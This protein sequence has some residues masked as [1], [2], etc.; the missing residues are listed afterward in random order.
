MLE[1][2]ELQNFKSFDDQWH[3]IGP[4]LNFTS[5]IGPNGCGKSN[6]IDAICFVL[7]IDLTQ[8]RSLTLSDLIHRKALTHNKRNISDKTSTVRLN[9]T[10]QNNNINKK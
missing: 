1:S 8:L 2:I 5:I 9:F 3:Y 4:F 6:I 7:G 10:L